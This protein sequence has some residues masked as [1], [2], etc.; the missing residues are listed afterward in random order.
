MEPITIRPLEELV[1]PSGFI[2][3]RA[4]PRHWEISARVDIELPGVPFRRLE[5]PLWKSEPGRLS[6]WPG[7]EWDG[8][9]GPAADT[10]DAWIASLFH[11]GSCQWFKGGF[12][13]PG[14]F[15]RHWLY[16]RILWVQRPRPAPRKGWGRIVDA[17]REAWCA[18]RA[19]L[20]FAGLVLG[21][22]P[23]A[24]KGRLTG[25]GPETPPE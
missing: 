7:Y 15:L 20:D 9:S 12:V 22:W 23:L 4:R 13:L 21:N 24:L 8:S 16:V 11:D 1:E 5:G 25:D 2:S 17:A 14:Y 19:G 6:F 10:P 18:T 3:F